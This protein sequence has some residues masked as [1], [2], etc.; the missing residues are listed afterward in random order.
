[1][2]D[3]NGVV[4]FSVI[5]SSLLASLPASA[6]PPTT[7]ETSDAVRSVASGVRIEGMASSQVGKAGCAKLRMWGR[8]SAGRSEADTAGRGRPGGMLDGCG[9]GPFAGSVRESAEGSEGRRVGG[10]EAGY[11]VMSFAGDGAVKWTRCTGASVELDHLGTA[12][13]LILLCLH[14]AHQ[15]LRH[16]FSANASDVSTS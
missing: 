10:T 1:M 4:D 9:V 6:S 5:D 14:R 15:I 11:A 2:D 3:L 13:P 7:P 8:S 12:R 16:W